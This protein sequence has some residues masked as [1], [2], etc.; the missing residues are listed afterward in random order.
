[1][2]K[3]NVYKYL[4][5]EG[6]QII[7]KEV[8]DSFGDYYDTFSNGN[9]LIRFSSSKLSKTVDVCCIS[10]KDNWFDIALLKALRYKEY[11]LNRETSF[12]EY[13]EFIKNELYNV[14]EMFSK[15]NYSTTKEKLKKLENKRIEQMFPGINNEVI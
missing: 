12:T 1:M 14:I 9:I 5:T 4:E 7:K 13:L 8:S 6:F 15:N 10:D 2:N 11:I 3:E